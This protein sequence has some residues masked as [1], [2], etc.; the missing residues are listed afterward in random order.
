[1]PVSRRRWPTSGAPMSRKNPAAVALGK[2]GGQ[3]K[4]AAKAKAARENGKKGGAPRKP[5]GPKKASVKI[6]IVALTLLGLASVAHADDKPLLLSMAAVHVFDIASTKLALRNPHLVES[7]PLM[8][9]SVGLFAL[10]G[11]LAACQLVVV[12]RMWTS[13]HK[14][15]AVI[16]A[17][18]VTTAYGVIGSHNLR[19]GK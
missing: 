16:T 8:R 12:H 10:K 2:L 13:G 18:G 6:L 5:I 17:L 1:M 19:V 14:R 7:N 15:A 3:V 9:S 11:G 4:S